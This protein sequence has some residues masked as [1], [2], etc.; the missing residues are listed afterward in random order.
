M[1]WTSA[2]LVMHFLWI[3]FLFQ[4]DAPKLTLRTLL[5]SETGSIFNI[6]VDLDLANADED[7][8][9]RLPPKTLGL[10]VP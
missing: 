2:F 8:P 6:D 9:S 5:A 7:R 10:P 4:A 1:R 3:A